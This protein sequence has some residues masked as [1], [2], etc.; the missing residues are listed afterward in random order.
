MGG[1]WLEDGTI[2]F[3]SVPPGAVSTA[4]G[5]GAS[6]FRVPDSGGTAERLTTPDPERGEDLHVLPTV[7]PGEKAVIFTSMIALG[8]DNGRIVAL[9]LETGEQ[10]T[11]VDVGCDA[12]YS[13]T[14]H[15]V[16]ARQ[17]ALWA[18]PFDPDRLE[19]T[20]QEVVVLQGIEMSPYAVPFSFSSD[21]LMVYGPGEV[22][23]G[24]TTNPRSLVWVDRQGREEA[25]SLPMRQYS[26]PRLS[27]D[28]TRL[29]VV[30]LGDQGFDLWV[31]DVRSGAGLRLTHEGSTSSNMV[32]I[33]TPEGGRIV[34]REVVGSG[35]GDLFWIAADGSGT[36]G[37]LVTG[38]PSDEYSTSVSA[39]GRALIFTRRLDVTHREV[40]EV[41]LDGDGTP[42]LLLSGQFAY[43]NASLSPDGRW[44]AYGSD[45]S[46]ERELY[47]QPYP[48]PGPKTPVSIGG[49]RELLWSPDGSEIFYRAGSNMMVVD[50][51]SVPTLSV[52]EPRVLFQSNHLASIGGRAR[53]YHVAPDGRFLMIRS[54][55]A[56][57]VESADYDHLIVVE[58]WLDEL[59]RLVPEN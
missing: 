9:S 32:P 3:V 19:V 1:T 25:L 23:T 6:L 49:G 2:I 40:W 37:P 36:P 26:N 48:G 38:N 28:G 43:G 13:P 57:G 7:L 27:P 39:D 22:T 21:G 16:F 4:S 5:G 41:P 31:Y 34:F 8:G 55:A 35:N 12:R 56:Q 58:N 42:T 45:E 15:L 29:A 50:V 18:A 11:L 52:S 46:G 14:G 47:L 30:V 10:R 44:L 20:G 33:W 54:G 51:Q 53:E 59:Q 17:G 24:I